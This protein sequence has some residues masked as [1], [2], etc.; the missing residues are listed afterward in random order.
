MVKRRR[1]KNRFF[2]FSLFALLLCT[3]CVAM[4]VVRSSRSI[5][6]VLGL[7]QG[8]SEEYKSAKSEIM[9]YADANGIDFS[10]YTDELI[11]LY[12]KN[13]EAREYVLEFPL[14]KGTSQDYDLSDMDLSQIPLYIQWDSRWGYLEYGDSVIGLSGCGPTALAIVTTY[15]KQDVKYDPVYMTKFAEENN[16]YVSG[17]GT[18]WVMMSEGAEKLGLIAK[19]LP[20]SE[21]IVA[22]EL[23][24]GHPIICIMGEGDFTSS[25]HFIV[26]TDYDDGMVSV[27]DPN[28]NSRSE[29]QWVFSEIEDQIRNLWSYTI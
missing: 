9:A 8:E 18:E 13:P 15:L 14:K 29:K 4:F 7:F 28:S 23:K 19:E 16:Y 1:K 5:T 24:A 11:A 22:S 6:G 25:A 2:T 21:D 12:E 3:F 27:K 26:L 17:H 20:L 10:E